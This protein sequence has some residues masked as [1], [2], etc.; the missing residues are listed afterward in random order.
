MQN[1]SVV[2]L[3]RL[4]YP[5]AACIA[6]KGH[7]VVG[8][9]LDTQTV[10]M[11]NSRRPVV[12]EPGVHDLLRKAG[13]RFKAISDA[14]EAVLTSDVTLV[15]VPTPSEADGTFSTQYV[16][17][18]CEAIAG[19]LAAK[20]TYHVVVLVSTVMPGG[21]GGEIRQILEQVSGKECGTEFGLGYVP[22]FVALGT[23]VRDFLNPDYLLIGES[24]ARSGNL[25]EGLYK[26]VCENDPPVVRMNF[27]NA[28]VTKLATN[29]F[30]STKIT[31]GNMI[32]L[33]RG[34]NK[35][36]PERT[37]CVGV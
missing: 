22:S 25:L 34:V 15:V 20:T 7:D 19:G 27:V 21:T 8:V 28:E 13:G 33:A 1:I 17:K 31:F 16:L 23:V 36:A 5:I 4:G 35:P 9:D 29:A 10:H 26:D 12:Q 2:G 3:G 30:V 18:A 24:D 32:A 14:G 6:A 11:V 37:I